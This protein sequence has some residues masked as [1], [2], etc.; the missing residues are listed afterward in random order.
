MERVEVTVEVPAE[1]Q[2]PPLHRVSPTLIPQVHL[3]NENNQ[4]VGDVSSAN[5]IQFHLA[6]FEI[7]I[8]M[9]SCLNGSKNMEDTYLHVRASIYQLQPFMLYCAFINL[10]IYV[11]H[12]YH[13]PYLLWNLWCISMSRGRVR[14][15]TPTLTRS[16][17]RKLSPGTWPCDDTLWVWVTPA[18]R[19]VADQTIEYT[20]CTVFLLQLV[21]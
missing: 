8:Y 13:P 3:F 14:T 4:K 1:G 10:Y 9:C 20:R 18:T 11:N 7:V 17:H 12:F 21:L 19:W 5:T 2:S 6:P 16:H 15:W